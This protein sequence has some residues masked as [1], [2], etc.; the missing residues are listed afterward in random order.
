LKLEG[1]IGPAYTLDSVNVDAQRCV[2]LYPEIIESGKGKEAQVAYLM[3]TPG[4]EQILE[5]GNGPIRLLHVDSIGRIFAVSGAQIYSLSKKHQW[6]YKFSSTSPAAITFTSAAVNTTTD[7]VT[8]TSHGYLTG[9]K[10]TLSGVAPHPEPLVV[11]D[12]YIIRVDN[13]TIKFASTFANALDGEA[14]NLTTIGAGS[15]NT[16]TPA[17]YGS[18][19]GLK[20]SDIDF[21]ANSFFKEAHGY[22]NG[23]AVQ[24]K[25]TGS[26]ASG[27]APSTTYYVTN[28][29]TDTFQL[30][31]SL[32]NATAGTPINLTDVD[33]AWVAKLMGAEGEYGGTAV[34]LAASSGAVKAASMSLGGNGTDS[35]TVFVDGENNYLL[36]DA[37][38]NQSLG[39]LGAV[40]YA[41]SIIDITND[42][43]VTTL[44]DVEQHV[45]S[46]GLTISDAESAAASIVGEGLD[47]MVFI[48]FYKDVVNSTGATSYHVD[49]TRVAEAFA[50]AVVNITDDITIKVYDPDFEDG[51]YLVQTHVDSTGI[52]ITDGTHANGALTGVVFIDLYKDVVTS[53]GSTS[54]RLL[55]TRLSGE[56]VTTAELVT[57]LSTGVL[58]GK[59]LIFNSG[60]FVPAVGGG[61]TRTYLSRTAYEFTGGGTQTTS[62]AFGTPVNTLFTREAEAGETFTTAELVE[63]LSTGSVSGK[64]V[65]FGDVSAISPSPA[66][67]STR[68]SLNRTDYTWS[69]GGSQQ[70]S[71]AFGTPV[72]DA[73]TLET[74][75]G[76]G[77]GSVPT[78]TQIVWS[79]GFFIVNQA[80]TN[81]FFVSDLQGFE[82]NALDFTS[83]EGSPDLVLAL[84]V[85]NR[86][87]YVF[88]ETTTEIYA[89]TG[90]AD[91]PFERVQGGFI[92]VG[93]LAAN[94]VAQASDTLF[95]LGRSKEGQG[96]VYAMNG[97]SPRRISTHA[98]E[99]AISGYAS[100][101]DAKGYAY[102]RNGH[103]FYVLN[104]TEATWVYDLATGMWHE[105]AYTNAGDLERHRVDCI[106][107]VPQIG[108]LLGSD[109]ETSEVYLI[110]ENVYADDGDAITRLRSSPHISSGGKWAIHS[111]FELDMETGIGLDGGV[112]GSSPTVMLDWSDDGGHTWSSEQ[113]ALADAGSGQIGDYNKRVIWRR[114]GKSRDRIYRVKITDPVKVRL[115]D[116][117][118]DVKVGAS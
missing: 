17:S 73:F 101:Q 29:T 44:T 1:F 43:T 89:N 39:V 70:T 54:Y 21:V 108:V 38:G 53:S 74:S 33:D 48:A 86:T 104:L 10:V 97:A 5:V 14:I 76:E 60:T 110:K 36:E 78:A 88:N 81:K 9:L 64:T 35:S 55:V 82:I 91:F 112:Q 23:L 4:L 20:H 107:Y 67:G 45:L 118:I 6:R 49:I 28:R 61:S 47:P 66:V 80:N 16:L 116:A 93:T 79:D 40:N 58:S 51:D 56:N 65:T 32:A 92:E 87:L 31:S 18:I 37:E 109:Y 26:Y 111:R 34:T 114:L 42:I 8:Y 57:A 30:A 77:Y 106:A 50:Q 52:T 62:S 72:Q 102:Q 63:A 105:R 69:G 95:W 24:F 94:S 68:T 15:S 113:F 27:I 11:G 19:Y 25:A 71:S 12:Y 41:Q 85:L 22:V 96:I 83:S 100:P 90:N 98:I 117:Q 59:D 75:V 46:S 2:N 115:I 103:T 13:D 7:A 3:A 99:Q 84:A